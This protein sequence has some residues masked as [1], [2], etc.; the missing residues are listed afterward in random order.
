MTGVLALS[1]GVG[2]A[3]LALGLDR[4][5]P[6]GALTVICNTG[7]DFDGSSTAITNVNVDIEYALE[8]LGS[9]HR[10]GP[11]SGWANVSI[12]DS[13]RAFAAFGRCNAL[14]PAVIGRHH[15][16]VA[17]EV[18]HLLAPAILMLKVL[19]S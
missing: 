17:S 13:L 15:T 7:D 6:A 5:L 9:G 8:S 2:G 14:T 12:G 10:D 1:G 18:S 11:F 4:I 19:L 3:K 16:V